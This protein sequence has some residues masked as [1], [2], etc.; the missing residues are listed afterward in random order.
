MFLTHCDS[1]LQYIWIIVLDFSY[2]R[3]CS[4]WQSLCMQR[5][6]VQNAY[7]NCINLKPKLYSM[8]GNLHTCLSNLGLETK[9]W[10]NNEILLMGWFFHSI[11]SL[12]KLVCK[13]LYSVNHF[14]LWCETLSQ[15]CIC[16]IRNIIRY[17]TQLSSFTGN[18]WTISNPQTPWPNI[19]HLK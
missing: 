3:Q 14:T 13:F 12:F 17:S 2:N 15:E 4:V 1:T 10:S 11:K 8:S 16:R 6:S 18:F 9:Q 19:A 5:N 7:Y